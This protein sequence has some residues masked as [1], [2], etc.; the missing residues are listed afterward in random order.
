MSDTSNL[1]FPE[2][3]RRL[4]VPLRVLRRAIRAGKIPAPPHLTAT[5]SLPAEWFASAQAAVEASPQALGR[6]TPQK[7]PAFARYEGTSAWRKYRHRV[8]SYAYFRARTNRTNSASA[9][10]VPD[11]VAT[12]GPAV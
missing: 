6:A 11:R 2:A 7:V 1:G 3:A 5:A 10:P 8:R 4:G 9:T 12:I